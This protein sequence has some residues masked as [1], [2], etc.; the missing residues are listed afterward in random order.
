MIL[1]KQSPTRKEHFIPQ[2]YLN[3]FASSDKRLYF[4]DL[5][6]LKYSDC[7]VSV[8]D[9]CYKKDLYEYKNKNDVII[10]TN[11]IERALSVLERMFS[12]HR[13]SMRS[14][15]K[16][17]DPHTKN[18]LSDEEGVFWITYITVQLLRMPKII[19]EISSALAEMIPSNGDSNLHRNTALFLLLPF[20]R[21]LEPE[22]IEAR[23]YSEIFNS[24]S[25]MKCTVAYD[26]LHRF[27]TSDCPLYMYAPTQR[28]SDCRKIVFPIDSSLCILFT[29]EGLYPDNGIITIN[30]YELES[31]FKSIAYASDEKLYTATR[32]TKQELVWI[33]SALNDKKADRLTLM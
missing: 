28:I 29:T 20:L 27:F 31:I 1:T 15:I 33:K 9:I 13:E 10:Y 2:V 4:F 25:K 14:R 22:S 11:T 16:L 24:I 6:T 26:S 12:K 30:D 32:F 5:N 23:L 18:F 8:K 17:T 3:G 7:M 19:N 21:Q